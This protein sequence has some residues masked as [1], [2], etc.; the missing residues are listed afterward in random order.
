MDK[1]FGTFICEVHSSSQDISG[2]AHLPGVNV[3][4][5]KGAAPKNTGDLPCIELV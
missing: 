5:G 2:G 1:N 4:N 3:G